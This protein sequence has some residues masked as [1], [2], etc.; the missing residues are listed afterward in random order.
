MASSSSR[1]VLEKLTDEE[2]FIISLEKNKKKCA[3]TRALMAQKIIWERANFTFHS[4]SH[5]I[6][7]HTMIKKI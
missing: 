1:S 7:N 4:E 5:Y 3:T 6:R 2:L